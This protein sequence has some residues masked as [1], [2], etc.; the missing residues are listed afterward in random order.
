MPPDSLARSRQAELDSNVLCLQKVKASC[1]D[2][3]I[4]KGVEVLPLDLCAPTA[5]LHVAAVKA[6]NAFGGSGVDYMIHNAGKL[7]FPVST[8][9]WITA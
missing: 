4:C 1:L 3:L 7:S 9:C 5:E 6:D 8:H 2:T